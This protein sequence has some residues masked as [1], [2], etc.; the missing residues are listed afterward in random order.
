MAAA[1]PAA[2]RPM[3][4][5]PAA[6]PPTVRP[7]PRPPAGVIPA[8]SVP[9]GLDVHIG[10]IEIHPV[11]TTPPAVSGEPARPS[12]VSAAE[13]FGD[14]IALRTYKPWAW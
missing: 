12:T 7:V 4:R 13:D 6:E 8:P 10:T 5:R 11:E 9:R 1:E 14:F 3:Y 2:A